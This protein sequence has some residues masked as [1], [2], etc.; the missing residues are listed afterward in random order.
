MFD[1]G[2]FRLALLKGATGTRAV[3]ERVGVRAGVLPVDEDEPR[4]VPEAVGQIAAC[5]SVSGFRQRVF[6]VGHAPAR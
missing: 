6:A 1:A 4:D 3:P 2:S 5:T